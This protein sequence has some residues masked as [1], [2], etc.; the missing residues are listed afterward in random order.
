VEDPGGSVSLAGE[1]KG[2]KEP[3][4]EERDKTKKQTGEVLRQWLQE[5][6]QYD[7]M[8]VKTCLLG[9]SKDS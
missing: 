2:A 7:E 3:N 5:R 6:R 8:E 4:I 1:K 9:Y